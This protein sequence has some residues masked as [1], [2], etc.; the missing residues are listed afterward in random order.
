[1]PD[2]PLV[3]VRDEPPWEYKRLDASEAPTEEELNALGADGWELVSTLEVQ[4]KV[5]LYFKR[6]LARETGN[7]DYAL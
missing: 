4:G 1:M 7:E 3:H 6:M 2:P 5:Y